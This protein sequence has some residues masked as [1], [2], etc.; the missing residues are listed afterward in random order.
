MF[1]GLRRFL[2]C[3]AL[4][5]M[6]N[7]ESPRNQE[8]VAAERLEGQAD[9]E[10]SI[11][12]A[13]RLQ[14]EDDESA[15]RNGV[16]DGEVVVQAVPVAAAQYVEGVPV[17]TGTS[18]SVRVVY[19]SRRGGWGSTER[20]VVVMAPT[21]LGAPPGGYWLRASYFGGATALCCCLWA[22]LFWPVAFCVPLCPCDAEFLYRAPDGS[23][24]Y[25]SGQ[26]AGYDD[27]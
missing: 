18:S 12:L 11:A 15:L 10:A 21:P 1:E 8:Q 22:L 2:F 13:I 20:D 3:V 27:Y 23:L 19:R 17:H 25:D 6:Q 4:A 7:V 14:Q 26:F 5:K 16:T 24:W 9:D